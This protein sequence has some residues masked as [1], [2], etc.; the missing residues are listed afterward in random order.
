MCA[1]CSEKGQDYKFRLGIVSQVLWCCPHPYLVRTSF[2]HLQGPWLLSALA[3][4]FFRN[5]LWQDEAASPKTTL[6]GRLT[7]S[8]GHAQGWAPLPNSDDS[9]RPSR[10][11]APVGSAEAL[12]AL[13]WMAGF[14]PLRCCFHKSSSGSFLPTSLHL[15]VCV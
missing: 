7:P 8:D 2:P 4:P 13:L 5:C 14:F 3:G 9:E 15:R 6:R 12:L 10:P 11:R 1:S